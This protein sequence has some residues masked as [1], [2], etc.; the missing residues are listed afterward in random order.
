SHT[1]QKHFGP[2]PFFSSYTIWPVMVDGR[3]AGLMIQVIETAPLHEKTLAMNEALLL[4]SLRQHELA[5]AANSSNTRLRTQV[6]E[7]KRRERDARMLTS[8]V[9]HR[10]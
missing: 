2:N 1:E 8:E 9:S 3:M 7:G 10:V 6:G 5:A 4:G